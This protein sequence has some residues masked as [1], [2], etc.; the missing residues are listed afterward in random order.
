MASKTA[1][2]PVNGMHCASCSRN[3]ERVV[4]KAAGIVACSVNF[5]TEKA[6]ITYDDK[7]AN[8]DAVN[9]KLMPYGYSLD[10]TSLHANDHTAGSDHKG[11][12][13]APRLEKL[14]EE[15]QKALFVFPLSI[16]VFGIMLWEITATLWP[17]V[18]PPVPF[19]MPVLQGILFLLASIVLFGPG[20]VFVLA[21]WQFFRLGK[22]N[23]DTLVGIGTVTAYLYST[24]VFLFPQTLLRFGFPEST[25]FDVA[26]VVIGFILFGKYLEAASKQRTGEALQ[27]LLA[28]QAKTALVIRN[29]KEQEVTIAEVVVG[30]IVIVKPAQKI[31]VDGTISEGASAIDESLVTGES[32]P[33][34]KGVGDRVIGGTLNQQGVLRIHATQ[35]GRGTVLS[36][37][38]DL[39]EQAQGSKAPIERIADT[40]SGIFTPVVLVFAFAVL[41][42][43]LTL[44]TFYLPFSQAVSLGLSA[45]FGVLI[46]ACPCAL[47]L[48]T[49]VGIIVGVG[50]GAEKGILIKNA[51]S[52]ELLHKVTTIVMDKTGTITTGKPVVTDI[53]P[54]K[55]MS[56]ATLMTI[57]A[58]LEQHSEHPLAHA[59]V[60]HAKEQHLSL[61]KV[62]EFVSIQ[63]KGLKGTIDKTTYYVGNATL[64]AERGVTL[65]SESHVFHTTSGKTP[66][67]VVSDKK[68]L[69]TVYIADTMKKEAKG[70]IAQLQKQHIKVVMLTGDDSN[71]A[72]AIAKQVGITTVIANVLPDKKADAIVKLKKE[73]EIVAMVGDG[74]NDAP[75]LAMA[76][77]GIAMSTGTDVAISTAHIT[78]L[79][80]DLQK[81]YEA[82]SI[83][84][85]TM[86]IIKQNLF[87]AFVYNILGIPLAAGVLYPFFGIMLSPVFA[88]A[89][90][91]LSSVS[92]VANALR[93]KR[94][95]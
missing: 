36:H 86:R 95:R 63:G 81:V 52:L 18:I 40:I 10:T 78:L 84:R 56:I 57:L 72:H 53:V 87:W 60:M 50:K 67:F 51:E 85:K 68:L 21:V 25:Y 77:V 76:D 90:M 15:K 14:G 13:A 41:L 26:I 11:H 75:A 32:L 48:A 16:F 65:A 27:K 62:K 88:G 5:A 1:I 59:I 34:D 44:G 70:V 9:T 82:M 73:G 19:P 24:A 46:I 80:G 79:H 38:I 22:A 42:L 3:I 30:D 69:G 29:G 23:M 74:V 54:E 55:G 39:V 8:L 31:P 92:V 28:L 58:S 71:T 94:I 7:V 6:T 37:I 43:W 4:K 64:L 93:L 45:F 17:S 33:V 89:A 35:V 61:K 91:A 12:A 83:S 2:V 47:G 20:R 66:M 49:P